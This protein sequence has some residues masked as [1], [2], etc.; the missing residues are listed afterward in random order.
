MLKYVRRAVSFRFVGFVADTFGSDRCSRV[1]GGV[2]TKFFALS[3]FAMRTE[4]QEQVD[5]YTILWLP[6]AQTRDEQLGEGK[7]DPEMKK[8]KHAERR[9][10][11]F[12][13][14]KTCQNSLY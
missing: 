14:F 9:G 7:M 4:V 5:G 13:V 1:D 11:D 10:S 12:V 3:A 8:I 6:S 2:S